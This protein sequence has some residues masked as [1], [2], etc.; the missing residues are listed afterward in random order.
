[1]IMAWATYGIRFTW[2]FHVRAGAIRG[3]VVLGFVLPTIAEN[4]QL[5]RSMRHG[6]RQRARSRH[7]SHQPR[8]SADGQ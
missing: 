8:S 6:D 4:T 3:G 2:A 5:D 7:L 1:M